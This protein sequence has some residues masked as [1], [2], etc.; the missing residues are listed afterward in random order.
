MAIFE[1]NINVNDLINITQG[2]IQ[3][4][5]FDEIRDTLIRSMRNIYGTDIDIS[6]ASADGQWVNEISLIINNCLQ[7]IKHAYDMLDPASAT[8]KYLDV[9]CSY[10]NIQRILPTKSVAQI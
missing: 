3:I 2:G 7:V 5:R 6:P 9:L 1:N 10:N 8:G 4:A